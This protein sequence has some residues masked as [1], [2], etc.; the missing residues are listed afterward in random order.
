MT[1]HS[2]MVSDMRK[3][4]IHTC[5]IFTGPGGTPPSSFVGTFPCRMV[6][7]FAIETVGLGSVLLPVWLTIDE[8][9]P[10]GAWTTD[11]FGMDATL[12]DQVAIPSGSPLKWWVLYTD[13]VVWFAGTPYYR[14]YLS[15]LPLPGP[16]PPSYRNA[17]GLGAQ[18]YGPFL[19]LSTPPLYR[20]KVGFIAGTSAAIVVIQASVAPGITPHILPPMGPWIPP[21]GVYSV[22]CNCWGPGSDGQVG[23][24]LGGGQGGCGGA[25]AQRSAMAVTPGSSYYYTISHSYSFN[26]QDFLGDSQNC[27]ADYG[28]AAQPGL[29]S[30]CF[31]DVASDG[32]YFDY[33]VMDTGGGGG[34]SA[35]P[36]FNGHNAVGTV[37]GDYYFVG[38]DGGTIGNPGI[39]G[40]TG[41]GGGGGGTGA[42]PGGV[43]GDGMIVLFY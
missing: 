37:G 33:P 40:A 5:D 15:L 8:Y 9:E 28:R 19:S 41:A 36:Y 34:G 1:T 30:N 23:T 29:A 13:Q 43:G 4:F 17:L 20:A 26:S 21:T 42:T 2:E 14:A 27:N 6:K 38:G 24:P 16:I 7:Q 11:G 12:S 3:P 39:D 22:L 10:T 31:A 35:A 32:G 18:Q 25:W